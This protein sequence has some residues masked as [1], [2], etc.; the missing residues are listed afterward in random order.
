M[1]SAFGLS[2]SSLVMPNLS[3]MAPNYLVHGCTQDKCILY[4]PK[5][6]YLSRLTKK[7]KIQNEQNTFFS[8][9]TQAYDLNL[10]KL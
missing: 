8:L 7:Q 1:L 2:N 3:R 10:D 4:Y 5:L 6:T 9:S